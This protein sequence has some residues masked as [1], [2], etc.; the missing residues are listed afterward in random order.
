[1]EY[2]GA[3]SQDTNRLIGYAI[4]VIYDEYVSFSEMKFTPAYLQKKVAAAMVYTMC[5]QYLNIDKKKYICD[6]ERSI[7]HITH[8]QDYLEKYFGFRKAYCNLHIMYRPFMKI[9][10]KCMYPFRNKL[11]SFEGIAMVNDVLA[12]LTMEEICRNCKKAPHAFSE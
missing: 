5:I 12:V 3:F 1:M 9:I 6:G 8:F 4:N 7:R 10:V 11:K 2:Y